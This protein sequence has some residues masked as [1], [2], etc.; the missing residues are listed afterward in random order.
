MSKTD[1]DSITPAMRSFIK[2]SLRRGSFFFSESTMDFFGCK[3]HGG[4]YE[5]DPD[6]PY[7]GYFITSEQDENEFA[8]V[9]AWEGERRFTIRYA[10]S[11]TKISDYS[12]FGEYATYE[13]AKKALSAMI[14]KAITENKNPNT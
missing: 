6:D 3:V 10:E 8:T 11:P 14:H 5:C 13:E 1:T 9:H 2:E 7:R 12:E 4:F